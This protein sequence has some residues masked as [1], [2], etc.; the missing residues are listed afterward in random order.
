MAGM[1]APGEYDLAGFAVGAVERDQLMPCPDQM[2]VGDIVLGLSSSGI[3]SNGFSLV[4][5][6]VEINDLSYGMPSPVSAGKTLGKFGSL[7][8]WFWFCMKII[9]FLPFSYQNFSFSIEEMDKNPAVKYNHTL[10]FY[11]PK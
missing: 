5:K 8:R 4:R 10:L 6:I 1:Y 11:S 3:H 7:V 9:L 2:T